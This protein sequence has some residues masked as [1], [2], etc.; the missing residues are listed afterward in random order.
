MGSLELEGY[1]LGETAMVIKPTVC[2]KAQFHTDGVPGMLHIR[3]SNSDETDLSL[4]HLYS[5]NTQFNFN[6]EIIFKR[7]FGTV[8]VNQE[9]QYM[10][11]ADK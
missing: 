10:D 7:D 1:K 3:T 4:K 8:P 5:G 2:P 6:A 9:L 11:E